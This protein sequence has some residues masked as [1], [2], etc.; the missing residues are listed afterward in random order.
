MSPERS[1]WME[2]MVEEVESLHKNKTWELVELPKGKKTIALRD[3]KKELGK[4]RVNNKLYV[5]RM[6]E[7]SAQTS[8]SPRMHH[9]KKVHQYSCPGKS[10][11]CTFSFRFCAR[12]LKFPRSLPVL[13]KSHDQKGE[14]P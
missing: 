12:E 7:S 13:F 3:P 8:F 10:Y 14:N 4:S 6:V 1:R 9:G 2:A 5:R 11:H